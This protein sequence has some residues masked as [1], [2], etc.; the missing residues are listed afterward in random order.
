MTRSNSV[1]AHSCCC[2]CLF[3][4]LLVHSHFTITTNQTRRPVLNIHHHFSP[5][6][7][8]IVVVPSSAVST[9]HFTLISPAC[10]PVLHP[11]AT[12]SARTTNRQR[13]LA[14][15]LSHYCTVI[16]GRWASSPWAI[17]PTP[18]S[19]PRPPSNG[20]T[21]QPSS[22]NAIARLST[23]LQSSLTPT[24]LIS[25]YLQTVTR[26]CSLVGYRFCHVDSNPLHPP[27]LQNQPP[28]R[29]F[30][31]DF[32]STPPPRSRSP[33]RPSWLHA[34][35]GGPSFPPSLQPLFVSTTAVQTAVTSTERVSPLIP[36]HAPA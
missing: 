7:H 25:R 34:T 23:C 2:W 1:G 21:P 15:S 4:F 9:R 16:I 18:C 29:I 27:L 3:F 6:D 8:H 35:L 19:A 17:D 24:I 26:Y 32:P 20:S 10:G 12:N 33:T 13:C 36:A 5:P 31:C 14:L 30:D 11:S 22:P 28:T